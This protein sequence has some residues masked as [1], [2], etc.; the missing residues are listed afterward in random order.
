LKAKSEY[1]T[2]TRF[3]DDARES[4]EKERIYHLARAVRAFTRSQVRAMQV[5]QSLVTS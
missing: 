3:I 4:I 1:D 5:Y 2:G